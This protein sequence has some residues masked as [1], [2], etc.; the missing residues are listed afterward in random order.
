MGGVESLRDLRRV[1]FL[2]E[3]CVE[4]RDHPCLVEMQFPRTD[5]GCAGAE[6]GW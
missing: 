3:Q 2:N 6:M 1:A 5:L 4:A